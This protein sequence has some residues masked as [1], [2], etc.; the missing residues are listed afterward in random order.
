M[1]FEEVPPGLREPYLKICT[2][3]KNHKILTQESNSPEYETEVYVLCSRC[4]KYL[5]FILHVN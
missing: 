3:G 1:N 4:G 2:C 5:E